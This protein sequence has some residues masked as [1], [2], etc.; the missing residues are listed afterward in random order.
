MTPISTA[1]ARSRASVPWASS[2]SSRST[3]SASWPSTRSSRPRAA[4]PACRWAWPTSRYVLW[5][6]FLRYQPARPALA[7]PRPL[8]A[9]GRARLDAALRAAPPHGLRPAARGAQALPPARQPHA[10][11]PEHGLTPGVET[12]TGPARPGLRQRRSAWRS[13]ARCWRARFNDAMLRAVRL[14]RVRHRQR[15]RP[16]GGRRRRK[17]P[18]SPVT[19]VS[20]T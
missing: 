8:R 19:G 1:R 10:R 4:T 14:P 15:R 7:G 20:A 6:R 2:T 9:L 17:P 18:R 16:D 13:P 12:T 11:A 5:T 3:P